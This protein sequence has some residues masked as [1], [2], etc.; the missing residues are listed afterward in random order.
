MGKTNSQSVSE[1]AAITKQSTRISDGP[2]TKWNMQ[3]FTLYLLVI[4]IWSQQILL[5]S[6]RGHQKMSQSAGFGVLH[7]TT[8]FVF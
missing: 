3:R 6:R 2:F 8:V 4:S 1:I 5:W 7:L